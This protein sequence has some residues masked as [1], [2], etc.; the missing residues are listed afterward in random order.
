MTGFELF[1][2]G[3]VA[4]HYITRAWHDFGRGCDRG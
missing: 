1:L 4:G 2:V 3:L